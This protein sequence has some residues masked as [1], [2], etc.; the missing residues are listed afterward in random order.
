M[1]AFGKWVVGLGLE[2]SK[3]RGKVDTVLFR[4]S[5]ITFTNLYRGPMCPPEYAQRALSSKDLGP[6]SAREEVR[7]P[8]GILS[9]G[10]SVLPAFSSVLEDIAEDGPP[11]S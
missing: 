7:V 3:K 6:E 8:V 1:H 9:V 11:I 10:V 5:V 4:V 2:V